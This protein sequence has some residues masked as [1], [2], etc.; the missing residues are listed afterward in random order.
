MINTQTFFESQSPSLKFVKSFY[1]N[2]LTI[3][4]SYSQLW[5][6]LLIICIYWILSLLT[7]FFI[8]Q[9][10]FLSR[11]FGEKSVHNP[12]LLT[13]RELAKHCLVETGE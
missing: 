5:I 1:F 12:K 2:M 13:M 7:F 4:K 10:T 8:G 9:L 6:T 3:T 11:I